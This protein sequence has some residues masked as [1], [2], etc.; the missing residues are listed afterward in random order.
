MSQ[1]SIVM[2]ILWQPVSSFGTSWKIGACLRVH[3]IVDHHDQLTL[4]LLL[5]LFVITVH[6]LRFFFSS[7]SSP[8]PLS[9]QRVLTGFYSSKE[10]HVSISKVYHCQ[11]A[12]FQ[13][14]L[15]LN[16]QL[17][18]SHPPPASPAL[19]VPVVMPPLLSFNHFN[20]S[21]NF[22]FC[23]GTCQSKPHL[24]HCREPSWA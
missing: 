17:L 7:L 21:R 8:S 13:R 9:L 23:F 2:N 18:P 12:L 6:F 15:I 3:N 11:H 24:P 1:I 22:L 16:K 4:L 5:L 19:L 14:P 10:S 20:S